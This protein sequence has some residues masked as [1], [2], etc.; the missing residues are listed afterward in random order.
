M[1]RRI[2]RKF[3]VFLPTSASG[4]PQIKRLAKNF[5]QS[6]SRG[7]RGTSTDLEAVGVHFDKWNVSRARPFHRE[8]FLRGNSP[9]KNSFHEEILLRRI[10]A[11]TRAENFYVYVRNAPARHRNMYALVLHAYHMSRRYVARGT[12]MYLCMPAY[13]YACTC[14]AG[15]CRYTCIH[16]YICICQT[17]V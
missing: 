12:C 3:G 13:V 8:K 14:V 9:I 4:M 10:S 15:R 5:K 7:S 2:A 11:N 6:R 17:F 1:N 16:T